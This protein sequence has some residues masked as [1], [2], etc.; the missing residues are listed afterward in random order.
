MYSHPV[1]GCLHTT[2]DPS[3]AGDNHTMAVTPYT[4]IKPEMVGCTIIIPSYGWCWGRNSRQFLPGLGAIYYYGAC[5]TIGGTCTAT[6]SHLSQEIIPCRPILDLPLDLWSLLI[7]YNGTPLLSHSVYKHRT[8]VVNCHLCVNV[9]RF[10]TMTYNY[11]H[12]DSAYYVS[13]NTNTKN[14]IHHVSLHW[15][16][17]L[18]IG[19]F[20]KII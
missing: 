16:N 19:A 13:N 6:C 15:Y 20:Y 1:T 7:H 3:P 8:E 18:C 2:A 12:R 17:N 4:I 14:V 11:G 5:D 9:V 10:L